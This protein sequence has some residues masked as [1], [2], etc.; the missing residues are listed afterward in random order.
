MSCVREAKEGETL[1]GNARF[2]G[3]SLDLIDAISKILGFKYRFEM[4]PDGKYGGYNKETKKWDGLI[5]QLLGK[6]FN[7]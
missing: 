3:Y 5:R 7:T 4:V 6:L 1:E 2:E